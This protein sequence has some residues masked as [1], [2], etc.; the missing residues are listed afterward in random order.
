MPERYFSLAEL[1]AETEL[2]FVEISEE[3]LITSAFAAHLAQHRERKTGAY[4]PCVVTASAPHVPA[5]H[6]RL[7]HLVAVERNEEIEDTVMWEI[8]LLQK[9]ETWLGS[10]L[11]EQ[12]EIEDNLDQ[13]YK[14]RTEHRNG[15][16]N[17]THPAIY[18]ALGSDRY[19]S[20][21]FVYQH[22]HLFRQAWNSGS[23]H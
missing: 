17:Q 12:S 6:V 7:P 4:E 9:A 5:G 14:L 11:P 15:T 8:L 23:Q 1:Q 20:I 10:E 16:L 19:I 21:L 22:I 3:A 13:L 18:E 2:P